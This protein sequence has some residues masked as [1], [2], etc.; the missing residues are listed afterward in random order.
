MNA[1]S[2]PRIL[3]GRNTVNPTPSNSTG[4][5]ITTPVLL[6]RQHLTGYSRS[7][8]AHRKTPSKTVLSRRSTYLAA[9]GTILALGLTA[10]QQGALT[11]ESAMT[12]AFTKGPDLA[13]SQATLK[14]A[15]ADLIAKQADSSTLVVTLTQARQTTALNAAQLEAQKL[16]VMSN[17]LT[18]YLNLFEG[19]ESIKVLTAQLELDTRNLDVT[20]AKL[21]AKNGTPLDVSKAESTLAASKQNLADAKAQL[22]I[23]SNRL[24]VLLGA[25]TTN[26]TVTAPSAFKETKIDQT[27]LENGLETRLP[28]VL[29]AAQALDL[30]KLNVQL[31]DNEYTP[32]ATLRD[33]KTQ[34]ENAQRSLDTT[35]TNAVTGLRDAARGVTNALEKVRIA[36]QNLQNAESSLT[37]DQT[38]F[39][40]GTISRLN[41]QTTEVTALNSRLASLQA[42]DTYLKALAALS[43]ASGVDQTGLVKGSA[44]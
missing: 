39:K 8:T 42:T 19:Q 11:L 40:S 35:R 26:L 23:L 28:S 7:H 30:A 21:A 25:N 33:F 9:L 17:V 37:Q 24:E 22:P 5:S 41:L 16:N 2:K 34:L 4:S 12:Q 43:L 13:S 32:P 38:K 31:S 10:A 6:E 44:L 18:A 29:Q 14:N 27:A 36:N 20:K 1:S 15:Q 3:A